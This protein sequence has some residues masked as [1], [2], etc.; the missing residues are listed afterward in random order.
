M[1]SDAANPSPELPY[2]IGEKC[3]FTFPIDDAAILLPAI[4]TDYHEDNTIIRVMV[5]TPLTLDTVPCSDYFGQQKRCKDPVKA[6][7]HHHSHG[8]TTPVEFVAPFEA[9]EMDDPGRLAEQLQYGK[10]VLCKQKDQVVWKRG[11]IIDQ[12]HGAHWRVRLNDTKQCIQVDMEQIMP[13]KDLLHEDT[14]DQIEEWSESE[15]EEEVVEKASDEFGGWQVHTTGF[16]AR[17]MAK[18]GYVEGSGL[19]VRG[20]GRINPIEAKPYLLRKHKGDD[21]S[22][23]GL[24]MQ[25]K[26]KHPPQKPKKPE[27]ELDMFGWMDNLLSQPQEKEITTS[28]KS[29]ASSDT[30]QT[31]Q[32]I[33]KLRSSVDKAK[34]EYV[35]AS[36]AYRRNKGSSV[37]NHFNKKLKNAAHQYE[38]LK[39]QLNELETHV[40]RAKEKKDMYTF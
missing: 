7:P 28:V 36:E 24:G 10:P 29:F 23:P 22:R 17:M 16:A 40:K 31:N 33:S 13:L 20:H 4:V 2:P 26:P 6:C 3:A 37:D 32:N 9:L 19:G 35:H 27:Q 5:L 11:R 8:Y 1:Y 39:K 15:R 25:H 14:A 30:R 18:M 34:A 12:L 21:K 38:S